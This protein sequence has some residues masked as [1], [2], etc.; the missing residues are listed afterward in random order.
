MGYLAATF[1]MPNKTRYLGHMPGKGGEYWDWTFTKP[2]MNWQ[3][4]MNSPLVNIWDESDNSAS[5]TMDDT[6]LNDRMRRSN[7]YNPHMY[8]PRLSQRMGSEK[9]SV[10]GFE[11]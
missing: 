4:T 5:I 6:L 2:E 11:F 3:K 7:Q 9:T 10:Q 1:F 8:L